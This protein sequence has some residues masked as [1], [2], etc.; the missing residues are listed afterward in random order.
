MAVTID[1]AGPPFLGRPGVGAGTPAGNVGRGAWSR[2]YLLAGF[3]ALATAA[4]L[5]VDLP[6]VGRIRE[7]V[8]AAGAAGTAGIVLGYALLTLGPAPKAALSAAAGLLF[9]WA[10]GAAVVW[11]A[12][13]LGAVAGFW[14][15]RW[16]GRDA[17]AGLIGH[18][19][20]RADDWLTRR[21]ILAVIGGRLLPLVPFTVINYAAGLSGLRFRD[22]LLGT[23]IGIIPGTGI[24]V[25]SG[26]LASRPDGWPWLVGG[27]LLLIGGAA[28]GTRRQLSRQQRQLEAAD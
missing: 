13:M 22:F 16:L 8:I 3:V 10:A 1:R 21:G 5:V 6:P 4:V 26:A 18:R 7:R 2:L 12:S 14:L 28:A 20:S 27:G 9:G 23:A 25:A 24:A 17:V 11:V 15:A 19:L